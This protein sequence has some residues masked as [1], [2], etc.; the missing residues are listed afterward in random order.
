[1][2]DAVLRSIGGA[3]C[4]RTRQGLALFDD[5]GRFVGIVRRPDHETQFGPAGSTVLLRR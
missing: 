2:V 4:I 5:A 3:R 1:M